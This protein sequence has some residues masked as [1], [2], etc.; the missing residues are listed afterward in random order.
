MV[1]LL[2]DEGANGLRALA[3]AVQSLSQFISDGCVTLQKVGTHIL[4][5][6]NS[7]VPQLF[8]A[9]VLLVGALNSQLFPCLFVE[10]NFIVCELP[11]FSNIHESERIATLMVDEG[12]SART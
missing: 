6:V 5:L 3:E 4:V 1:F 11:F 2:L 7:L 9:L 8:I 12:R 10:H